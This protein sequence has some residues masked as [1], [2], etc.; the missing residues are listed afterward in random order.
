VAVKTWAPSVR[1]AVRLGL[2]LLSAAAIV[3]SVSFWVLSDEDPTRTFLDV[4]PVL[5]PASYTGVGALLSTLRPA[6]NVGWLCLLIG[7]VW[8]SLSRPTG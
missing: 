4:L 1:A 3:T 7:A 2:V 6:N 8:G 5:I